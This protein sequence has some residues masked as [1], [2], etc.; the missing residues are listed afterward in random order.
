MK[1]ITRKLTKV[2]SDSFSIVIPK[3]IIR[4]Y[5]WKEKQKI[6]I[7]DKGRGLIQLRDWRTKK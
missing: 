6:V 2:S 7:E 3:E 1:K 4:K 5:G